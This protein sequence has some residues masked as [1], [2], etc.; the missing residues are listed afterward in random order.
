MQFDH[1]S[2]TESSDTGIML[3]HILIYFAL[4]KLQF[5]TPK[6]LLIDNIV[7]RDVLENKFGK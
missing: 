2:T 4:E 6:S 5:I 1:V 7:Y 3:K